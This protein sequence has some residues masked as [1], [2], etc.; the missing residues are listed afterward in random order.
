MLTRK[1]IRCV[2]V[3]AAILA[4]AVLVTVAPVWAGTFEEGLALYNKG[5]YKTAAKR[6]EAAVNED[7][8]NVE[9]M[10]RLGDCY[11]NLY[12]P[13][14]TDYARLAIEAYNKVIEVDPNDP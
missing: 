3:S 7:P 8:K 10:K 14:K 5:Q 13:Q 2:R 6:F 4:L 1:F 9:A 11:Y 12:S